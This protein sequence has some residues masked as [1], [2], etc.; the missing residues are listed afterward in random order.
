MATVVLYHAECNDGIM[1]AAVVSYF[2]KDPTITYYPVQYRQPMPVLPPGLDIILVDFCHDNLGAM[3]LLLESCKSMRII[4][5]H[6]GS[7]ASIKAL[8]QADEIRNKLT[9]FF[10]EQESG[11]SLTWK[12][13]SPN[14]MPKVVQ[15][16]RNH[17]LHVGKTIEDDYFFYGVLTENQNVSFWHSLLT[18]TEKVAALI[19]AGRNIYNFVLNTVLPQ[20]RL[21][22][23]YTAV[24]GF[25]IPVVNVNRVLQS[26]VLEELCK[27]SMVAMAYEDLGN[28]KRKWSVRS[29]A[30]THGAA[31]RIAKE[32][33]G[34]GHLNAA[35]FVTDVTWMPPLLENM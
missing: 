30:E 22:L 10:D 2:E 34:N 24:S 13:Y 19:V 18:D 9:V 35:G 20:A 27:V 16:A 21:K 4:D 15:L 23:G 8:Q 17:D 14:P 6:D 5:H 11:A 26:L 12:S 29:L 33:G 31:Q 28:G 32:F 1:A 3:L 7:I 25:T